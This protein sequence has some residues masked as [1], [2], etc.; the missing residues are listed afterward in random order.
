MTF[1]NISS[2]HDEISSYLRGFKDLTVSVVIEIMQ[3][4]SLVAIG[5]TLRDFVLSGAP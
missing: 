5:Q 1:V 3:L 2:V 4:E